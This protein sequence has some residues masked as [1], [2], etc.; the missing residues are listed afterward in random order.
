MGRQG[1]SH[2][3]YRHQ[4]HN[5]K[6]WLHRPRRKPLVLRGARQVGKSTLIEL[7]C[8]AEPDRDLVT[9]NL[10]RH[11]HLAQAFASND[12][13]TIL[14]LVGAVSD[15]PLSE[16]SILFLDEIQAA[17]SAFAS[18][19]Y[20]F[21]DMPQRPVVAAGSL[22]EFMLS[23]HTFSMPVGR[24]E[25]LNL[26][27]MTFTEF[28]K[29]VGQDRLARVIETF[30]WP[31]G[32]DP[33]GLHPLIH[34]RLLDLLRLYQFVGGMPEAVRVYSESENL[35]A[36]SAVHAAIVDTWRDDFPK[37]AARRDLTRMLRV[38]HF[39]AR[40]PGRKV[41]YSNVSPDDQSAT[42]RR[43]IDLLE[44]ARVIARVT[45]SQCSGLPLQA[46]I[47]EK[48]FKLIFLDVGLMNAVCGLGWQT[49]A[50]QTPAQLVNAG[51]AAE[52]FI[53]QHLQ[54]LLAERPNRALTYWLREGRS[55]NAEVDY[56]AEFG[57]RIVPIEVKAGRAGTLK[58]L[59]QFVFEKRVPFAIRFHADLP[60]LQTVDT[61]VRRSHGTERVRYRLLSL[62]LYLVER[63]PRI[64]DGLSAV[65]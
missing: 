31:S 65:V 62:P 61:E 17:P 46:D 3:M 23:D 25:Y 5:L 36:V 40:H 58:S 47:N 29:A 60:A 37:Y 57:G 54:Y 43:D 22:I 59:H 12:P 42:V 56:V 52:Q 7:F 11:P 32:E 6:E 18:L 63:L 45:H 19:R 48:V 30:E 10:E 27:P 28:L 13:G 4:L 49:L 50:N 51:P 41:K 9:V 38:F 39:A 14:N 44:M 33:A 21:E 53:G 34:R 24:I 35:P 16:R 8:E 20:F 15:T 1:Y 64:V 55:S 26:G 2:P